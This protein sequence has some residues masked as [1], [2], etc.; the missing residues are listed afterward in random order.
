MHVEWNHR[1]NRARA[2]CQLVI[3]L[4]IT[5]VTWL[6]ALPRI[7]RIPF[8]N[9]HIETMEHNHIQVDAMFYTELEWQPPAGWTWWRAKL[10][11]ESGER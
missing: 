10:D 4:S 5:G 1:R 6:V 3:G 7:A 8:V 9:Q 11:N 2:W